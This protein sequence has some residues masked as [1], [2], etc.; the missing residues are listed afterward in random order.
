M[1]N[2]APQFFGERTPFNTERRALATLGLIALLVSA[3]CL[4]TGLILMNTADGAAIAEAASRSAIVNSPANNNQML[5]RGAI[6]NDFG[7][8]TA[9][10]PPITRIGSVEILDNR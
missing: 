2:T 3:G 5:T 7:T 10:I 1:C 9:T 6:E 8:T 4:T